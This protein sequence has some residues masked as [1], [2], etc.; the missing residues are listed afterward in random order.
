MW[1]KRDVQSRS[2]DAVLSLALRLKNR[3]ALTPAER[4]RLEALIALHEDDGPDC[5]DVIAVR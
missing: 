4:A 2:D 1:T 5:A 3:L